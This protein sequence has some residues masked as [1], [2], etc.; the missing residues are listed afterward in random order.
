MND[1]FISSSD[2]RQH[3]FFT[4]LVG[5]ITAILS[6]VIFGLVFHRS[7]TI[8]GVFLMGGGLLIGAAMKKIG[9]NTS[10]GSM[11]AAGIF[12]F[13]YSI[14]S[15]CFL[16]GLSI[17]FSIGDCFTE[18]PFLLELSLKF[19]T[20]FSLDTLLLIIFS[21]LGILAAAGTVSDN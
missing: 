2:D 7:D 11:I 18:L 20:H 5:F 12:S 16:N 15:I 17:G 3:F 8:H 19:L 13:I 14:L 6:S 4:L 21:L 10:R 1:D 9:R